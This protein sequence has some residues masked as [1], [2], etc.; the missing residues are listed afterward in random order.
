MVRVAAGLQGSGET[1]MEKDIVQ[2][3]N[4]KVDR[5]VK[6]DRSRGKIIDHKETPGPY[7][8]IP[9]VASKRDALFWWKRAMRTGAGIERSGGVCR[10]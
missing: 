6:L 10:Q 8:G 1:V 3:R 9:V 4:P 2:I 7:E 5:Y